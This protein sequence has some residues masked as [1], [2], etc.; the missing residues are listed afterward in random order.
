MEVGIVMLLLFVTFII[1]LV[2]LLGRQ[3]EIICVV[4]ELLKAI[5][6]V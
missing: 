4:F 5:F 1:I 6:E 3:K 2:Y